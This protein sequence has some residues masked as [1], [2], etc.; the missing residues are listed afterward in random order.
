ME[1]VLEAPNDRIDSACKEGKMVVVVVS[2]GVGVC[3]WM[4][5]LAF[6]FASLF[7]SISRVQSCRKH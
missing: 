5:L 2:S 7:T 6:F 4:T 3:M 1:C